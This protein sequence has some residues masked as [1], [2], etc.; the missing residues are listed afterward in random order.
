M[1]N[2]LRDGGCPSWT[3]NNTGAAGSSS[4]PRIGRGSSGLATKETIAVRHLRFNK[5]TVFTVSTS[6]CASHKLGCGIDR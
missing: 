6:P 2:S 4:S 3:G 5:H 1:G